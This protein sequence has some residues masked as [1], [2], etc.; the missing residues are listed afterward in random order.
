MYT[1]AGIVLLNVIAIMILSGRI[2]DTP[3]QERIQVRA[4]TQDPIPENPVPEPVPEEQAVD[5]LPLVR[6]L[7]LQADCQDCY[8]IDL[9]VETLRDYI[10][11]DVEYAEDPY[12]F[13]SERL[14]ALAFNTTIEEYPHLVD[15]WESTGYTIQLLDKGTWYVLPTLNAPYLSTREG[16]VRGRVTATY[17][18]MDACDECYDV[19][20]TREFLKESRIIPYKERDVDIASDEGK[21]LREQYGITTVP[22]LILDKEADEYPNMRPGWTIV[23]SIED[24]GSY[25]L[26]DLQKLS[27]V[28]YDLE[29]E[30]VMRP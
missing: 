6:T 10:N 1:L 22:T 29:Q 11:M 24:D 25:I 18:T 2:E 20:I 21:Q 23:G 12:I 13:K 16:R 17:L 19:Q 27:V 30:S 3:V 4:P 15:N 7:V 8:D 9:Y 14:P 28:Y 5:D 26:R